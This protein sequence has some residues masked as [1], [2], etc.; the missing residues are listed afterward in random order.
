MLSNELSDPAKLHE[1]TSLLGFGLYAFC[2][3][4]RVYMERSAARVTLL[5]NDRTV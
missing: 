3:L 4:H 1:Q 5:F 2:V